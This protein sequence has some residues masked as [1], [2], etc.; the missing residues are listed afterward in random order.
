MLE[1]EFLLPTVSRPVSLDIGPPFG[2]LDQVL[3]CSSFVWQLRRSAFNA[4]SLTRK[5]VCN[6]LV[7]CFWVLPEQSHINRSPTE[8]TAISYCLICDSPNLEGQVPVFISPRNRVAQIY[9]RAL[10]SLSVASYDSRGLRW[11]YSNPPPHR[12]VAHVGVGVLLAAYSQSTSTSG[13]RASLWD[14]WPDFIL[15]GSH[16]F[17]GSGPTHWKPLWLL[18]SCVIRCVWTDQ[19]KTPLV[20]RYSIVA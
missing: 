12:V 3:S 9:P 18:H 20:K 19:L 2:T 10:H 5:R 14:P 11:K 16:T 7:N 4:S 6:L 1:L 8:L 13:Y 17:I 15:G